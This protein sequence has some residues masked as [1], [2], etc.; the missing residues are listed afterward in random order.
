MISYVL[1]TGLLVLAPPVASLGLDIIPR[2]PAADPCTVI[3]GKTWVA[4][5]DVRACFQSSKVDEVAKENVRGVHDL[6]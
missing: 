2:E 4:P 5:Q 1:V 6:N 3:A